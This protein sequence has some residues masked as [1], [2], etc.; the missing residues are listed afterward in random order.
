MRERV[1]GLKRKAVRH[2]F[3]K[4]NG[5]AVKGSSS[6]RTI[7]FDPLRSCARNE[8]VAMTRHPGLK[9]QICRAYRQNVDN[10]LVVVIKGEN[11]VIS[12]ALLQPAVEIARIGNFEIG[13]HRNRNL[14]RCAVNSNDSREISKR[15][16]TPI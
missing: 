5:E 16:P 11:H 9:R 6:P 7:A 8:F 12:Y 3:L 13:V 4:A 2:P 1:V 15:I 10:V 14:P